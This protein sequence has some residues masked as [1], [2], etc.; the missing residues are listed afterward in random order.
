M[1]QAAQLISTSSAFNEPI[2]RH[3]ADIAK[4]VTTIVDWTNITPYSGR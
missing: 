2:P 3:Y 4:I 1:A